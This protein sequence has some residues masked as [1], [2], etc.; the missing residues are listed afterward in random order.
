MKKNLFAVVALVAVSFCAQSQNLITGST[1]DN[2]ANWANG[3]CNNPGVSP[4]VGIVDET[5]YGGTNSSN[6]I[7]EIDVLSCIQQDVNITPGTI[8]TINFD[9]TRR[10]GCTETP[11]NP[12]I[13][14]KV[15]GVTSNTVYS[16]VDYHYS[17]GTWV[18]YTGE[19]QVWSI[20]STA[21][22]AAVKI[23]VTAIDNNQ[24]CGILVDNFTM[25]ASG[26]LPVSLTS[27]NASPKNSGVELNWVTVSE[28]NS[29]YFTIL[30][31]KD[32]VNF[33]EIGKVNASGANG[34]ASYTFNDAAPSAGFNYYRLKQV[35][36]NSIFKLS[37]IIKVNLNATDVNAMIYPT[38]VTSVVN[39]SIESPKALKLTVMVTDVRGKIINTS[40]QSFTA[41]TTQKSVNVSALASGV[42]LLTVSDNEGGFK[43]AMKFSKN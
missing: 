37:G 13:N 20:V 5:A 14:V 16:S 8:Y 31:S 36:K 9:A 35:D 40:V 41:G 27:F 17:N 6:N 4:E 32:G 39:Y 34:G 2:S 25:V 7:A 29:A 22:D 10:I 30:R 28:N 23:E 12:G 21:T 43:K 3:P 38:V 1:M 42:Y 33:T 26:I 18:G 15:T 11:A 19:T 24:E